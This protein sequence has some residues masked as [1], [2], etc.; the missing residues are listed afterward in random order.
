MLENMVRL[1][2]DPIFPP[3]YSESIKNTKYSPGNV[4][5]Q[6]KFTLV[7]DSLV[8]EPTGE[9]EVITKEE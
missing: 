7:Y 2:V 3:P 5:E 6:N 4:I 9:V 1:V 8:A